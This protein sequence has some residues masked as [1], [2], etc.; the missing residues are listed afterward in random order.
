MHERSF[1]WTA[2]VAL[3]VCAAC[4][5]EAKSGEPAKSVNETGGAAQEPSTIEEAQA[6]LDRA[7]AQLAAAGAPTGPAAASATGTSTSTAP[8]EAPQAGGAGG[9]AP[10]SPCVTACQA[11]ASMHRAVD[12]ICR[13]AGQDDARC[14][15][16]KK[17]LGDSQAKVA[18][19]G[20]S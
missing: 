11:I 7:K 4:G 9:A 1:A 10:A 14:S 13:M 6:Q 17:T 18:S 15:D 20:C 19:C 5:G 2:V 8:T 16:A 3:G 12:A